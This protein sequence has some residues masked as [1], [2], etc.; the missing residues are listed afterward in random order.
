MS[1]LILLHP[2]RMD[3]QNL[4]PA[5][6]LLAK[7]MCTAQSL[8]QSSHA[9]VM[10]ENAL[11]RLIFVVAERGVFKEEDLNILKETRTAIL[12]VLEED[13]DEKEQEDGGQHTRSQKRPAE[14]SAHDV[15]KRL[16]ERKGITYTEPALVKA[17]PSKSKAH[18]SQ[19]Q[20]IRNKGKA[21]LQDETAGPSAPNPIITHEFLEGFDIPDLD[22][23]DPWSPGP[24][25]PAE[26]NGG[27][28]NDVPLSTNK[29][30]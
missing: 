4:V 7:H 26:D 18:L 16:R 9:E 13:E 28:L 15:R 14:D 27:N 2:H 3:S 5:F 21:P 29:V 22:E 12:G 10:M 25:S 1:P 6:Q 11:M 19:S 20:A 23:L 17:R 30:D 24:E 8:V